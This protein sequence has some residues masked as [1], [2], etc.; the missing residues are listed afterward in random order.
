MVPAGGWH[1]QDE[2]AGA[3]CRAWRRVEADVLRA[4]SAYWAC[5]G[6]STSSK[7]AGCAQSA[8]PTT[9]TSRRPRPTTRQRHP[10]R[11]HHRCRQR[12][13]LPQQTR[14][15]TRTLCM[16]LPRRRGP[17]DQEMPR[18]TRKFPLAPPGEKACLTSG[19]CT[20]VL[21]LR[22]GPGD[23]EVPRMTRNFL[24]SV[25]EREGVPS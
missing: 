19:L 21:L 14:T 11:L 8:A 23:Q 16:V 10:G 20:K 2:H 9:R 12:H 1:Y 25:G 15:R 3:L 24:L 4:V 17:V 7:G 6:A 22:R 5:R 18:M 13:V